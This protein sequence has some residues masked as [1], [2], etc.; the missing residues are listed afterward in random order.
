MQERR[1]ADEGEVIASLNGIRELI[2]ANRR[3]TMERFD[4]LASVVGRVETQTTRTNGRVTGL[5]SSRTF[6][7]GV[8]GTVS[9]LLTGGL[10]WLAFFGVGK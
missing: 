9:F 6:L 2:A 10:A 7:Y 4:H 3:E 5:E 1:Y 8:I